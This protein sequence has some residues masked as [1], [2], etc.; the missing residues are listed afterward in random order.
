M[1]LDELFAKSYLNEIQ[2]KEDK[3]I[4]LSL[5]ER[6]IAKQKRTKLAP[7]EKFLNKFKELGVYVQHSDHY[8]KNTLTMEGIV[9][10]LFDF[11][12]QDSSKTW[13]P[14]I[15]ILIDHP[16]II[17][18]AIPNKPK[19][20]GV[21]VIKVA[22]HHPDRYL[23]DQNFSSYEAACSA[24]GRFL[25]RCTTSVT[26]DPKTYLKEMEQK[27]QINPNKISA[28]VVAHEP[29][30][31]LL[32]KSKINNEIAVL[33]DSNNPTALKKIGQFFHLNKNIEE[34][35]D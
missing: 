23:L 25:G 32:H 18:I 29:N 15:S 5:E 9:P 22:S 35:D 20:E 24:L 8:T 7:I 14:G 12:L 1:D 6:N 10:Q 4:L 13:A 30:D 27:K 21:V 16:A 2:L 28:H 34:D 26:K 31:E 33:K 17:E 3:K 11:Y 19:E